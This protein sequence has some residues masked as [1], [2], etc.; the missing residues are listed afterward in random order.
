MSIDPFT[1]ANQNAEFYRKKV[2]VAFDEHPLLDPYFKELT[3]DCNVS[4]MSHHWH[5]IQHACNK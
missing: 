3:T 4:T 2:K 1:S 5:M